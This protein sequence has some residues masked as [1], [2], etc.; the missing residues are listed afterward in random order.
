MKI[1]S[2]ESQKRY[3]IIKLQYHDGEN[4]QTHQHPK[5]ITIVKLDKNLEKELYISDKIDKIPFFHLYFQT[6]H[7]KRQLSYV[8]STSTTSLRQQKEEIPLEYWEKIVSSNN[9]NANTFKLVETSSN[10]T[11]SISIYNYDEWF[12][13]FDNKKE[14]L[15]NVFN[16]CFFVL[17]GLQILQT[18]D[19][20]LLN[21]SKQNL[22]FN[23]F[24]KPFICKFNQCI[25]KSTL[26]KNSQIT[27]NKDILYEPIEMFVID[28]LLKNIHIHSLSNH[29]IELIVKKYIENH[30]IISNISVHMREKYYED[31][32]KY[33]QVLKNKP[34]IEILNFLLNHA[35]TW[36]NY[37]FHMFFLKEVLL[38]NATAT[39][40]TTVTSTPFITEDSKV[41]WKGFI[42]IFMKNILCNPNERHNIQQ[43]KNVVIDYL[44]INTKHLQ[45]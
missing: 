14:I 35:N 13:K 30:S 22:C 23:Q 4:S 27:C 38:D 44:H 41:F 24:G 1:L 18:N 19:I 34:Y 31:S 5:N 9:S 32:V 29:Q 42:D 3:N 16:L 12:N 37:G 21:F 20:L 28:F 8:N 43:T 40:P 10:L 15:S 25:E 26:N 11:N 45:I 7:I 39:V 33:L 2:D 36:D 6:I 17:D